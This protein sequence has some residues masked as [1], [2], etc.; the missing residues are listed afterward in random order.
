[1]TQFFGHFVVLLKETDNGSF[2]F[3]GRH[4]FQV[5]GN[6]VSDFYGFLFACVDNDVWRGLNVGASNYW[7]GHH[8]CTWN[9]DHGWNERRHHSV[10]KGEV[11]SIVPSF[12]PWVAQ[13]WVKGVFI[14]PAGIFWWVLPLLW[15][16]SLAA[17]QL[18]LWYQ[19]L[20]RG[21]LCIGY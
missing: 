2:A 20:W 13:L 15:L 17:Y 4:S 8:R 14:Y 7:R 11:K 3:E 9:Q 5:L 1:M 19:S 10:E 6:F 16:G 21:G 12:L 18:W